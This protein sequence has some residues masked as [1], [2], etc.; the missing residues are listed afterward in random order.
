MFKP[1]RRQILKTTAAVAATSLAFPYVNTRARAADDLNLFCWDGYSDPRL[2]D[3]FQK[4]HG[5]KVKY[6]LLISDPD[7]I[8]RLRAGE[9]KI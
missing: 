6:E 4:E 8:N 7:A 3:K 9:N 1:T 2:I 5:T